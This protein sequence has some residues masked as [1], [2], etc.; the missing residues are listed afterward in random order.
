VP[1]IGNDWGVCDPT[2]RRNR[3]RRA[4]ILIE[5]A[6]TRILVDTSPDLREQL[7]DA[8][9]SAVDAVIWTHDHADHCHG[10]DDLRQL[11]H[12][13]GAPVEG[14]ARA[15][16]IIPLRDRFG[17]AFN[18]RDGYPAVANGHVLE[19]EVVIGDIR[20]RCVDQPH[21]SIT[22][23]GLRF[24]ANGCAI[25]YATDFH[26]MT[27]DMATLYRDL[28]LWIVDALRHRPHP[29]HPHLAMTLGWIETFAPRRA[30][31]THMDH[32]MDYATLAESL[33][34][35]VTPG[36]DGLAIAVR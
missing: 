22:S 33:P 25:G 32:S 14:Y 17:Y 10:L 9:V 3:R 5:T 8:E 26:E 23:A 11:Y 34:D 13:R 15:E 20:V 1:R 24:E 29:T 18:G 27:P 36:Y 30:V 16:T 12:A 2:D 31:L 28:D 6:S 19:D 7:L 35:N 4:S 21:G